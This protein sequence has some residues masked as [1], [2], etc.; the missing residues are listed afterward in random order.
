MSNSSTLRSERLSRSLRFK[1]SAS[2]IST[3]CP[4]SHASPSGLTSR[5]ASF[6]SSKSEAR[7]PL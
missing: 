3:N 2:R 1:S 6:W 7:S 4:S 5:C